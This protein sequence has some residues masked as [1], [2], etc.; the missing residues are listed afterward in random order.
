MKLTNARVVIVGKQN[1]FS[2]NLKELL[3]H[4]SDNTS[5]HEQQ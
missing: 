2:I 3:L 5:W 4:T 1:L